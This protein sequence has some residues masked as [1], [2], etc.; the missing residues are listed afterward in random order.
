MRSRAHRTTGQR[1]HP[2]YAET[3][4]GCVEKEDVHMIGSTCEVAVVGAG[5]YGLSA[6]AHLRGANRD[7]RLFG[8][9]MEFW[10]HHMPKGMILRSTWRG[11]H[12]SDPGRVLTPEAFERARGIPLPR[13]VTLEDF[14][15]YGRWFQ[16]QAIPDLDHRH[17]V[18]IEAENNNFRLLLDDGCGI[19][20][21][22]VVI[23]CGL[24]AFARRP[25]QF[26]AAGDEFASHTSEH[27]DLRQFQ[28]QRLVVVGAG[29]SAIES[30]AL[31]H[32]AGAAVEVIMR[33]PSVRWL[34]HGTRLHTWLHSGANPLRSVLYT[35]SNI[36][37]PGLNWVVETP[38]LFRR[39][40]PD[41]QT[42]IRTRTTRPAAA[43]WLR[44]RT[45]DVVISTGRTV[46]AADRVGR[47]L[48]LTLDD[49]TRRYADHVLL[50]TGYRVNVSRYAVLAR[51]LVQGIRAHN[52]YPQL[53]E[54]FESTVPG[55]HFLG[56]TAAQTFGPLM[57]FVAGT[58]Y[59]SSA[60]TNYILVRQ[61]LFGSLASVAGHEGS[62][63]P[64]RAQQPVI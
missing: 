6:T 45:R 64:N 4:S 50:A 54:G 25:P 49:S 1:F 55:L 29:Q 58:R 28:G 51:E 35:P 23:A 31:L 16:R 44:P 37:A 9:A 56:A 36:G 57:G 17:V 41:L 13:E 47:Q 46:S 59:A 40:P 22:R 12:I 32:E 20:A 24:G 11:C 30:A 52:G 15:A 43:G 26:D 61:P 63:S 14:V 27:R 39:L 19:G 21:R 5:P 18:R 8:Q 48:C 2:D 7:V 33:A 38:Q 53:N 60:L 10:Q 62:V 34:R 42:W 3:P